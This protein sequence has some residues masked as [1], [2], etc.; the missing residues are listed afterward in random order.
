MIDYN[1]RSNGTFINSFPLSQCTLSEFFSVHVIWRAILRD[2]SYIQ[3]PDKCFILNDRDKWEVFDTIFFF[4]CVEG[5]WCSISEFAFNQCWLKVVPG[6]G[7][8]IKLLFSTG[9]H[10]RCH[11]RGFV[12][13]Q[14]KYW[15][16]LGYLD[17]SVIYF[18][19]NSLWWEHFGVCN[20]RA[21]SFGGLSIFFT[22][23]SPKTFRRFRH[24]WWQKTI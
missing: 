10:F 21:G 17:L 18:E 24:V 3:H 7:H 22:M 9:M 6:R 23:H 1:I 13:M 14:Q 11:T 20:S 2:T 8:A 4:F 5:V 16:G 12:S 15:Q 19:K